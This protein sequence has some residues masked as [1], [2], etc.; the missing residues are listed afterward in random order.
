MKSKHPDT[1]PYTL[2]VQAMGGKEIGCA[3]ILLK[4]SEKL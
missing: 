1:Q 2:G 4:G 3:L